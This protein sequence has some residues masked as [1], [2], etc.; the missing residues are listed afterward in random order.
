M[1]KRIRSFL[2]IIAAASLSVMTASCITPPTYDGGDWR[3]FVGQDN[4]LCALRSQE[5]LSQRSAASL[6]YYFISSRLPYCAGKIHMTLQRTDKLR[7]GR[8]DIIKEGRKFEKR[9][10]L[11]A[12]SD[13]IIQDSNIWWQQLAAHAA[14]QDGRVILYTH[15]YNESF[16]ETASRVARFKA[17]AQFNGPIIQFSWPSHRKA[18]RYATD[19]TNLQLYKPQ[20]AQIVQTLAALPEVKSL[21]LISHSLGS[22]LL[23]HGL[24]E[25]DIR[26]KNNNGIDYSKKITN[27]ILAAPDIDK[28][29]FESIASQHIMTDEKVANG[30]R[31]TIYSSAK[32]K[33][34]NLSHIIN[35][36]Q[37][38]GGT[39]CDD[40]YA[41]ADDD[42]MAID[43]KARARCYAILPESMNAE[44]R[45]GLHIVDT[46]EVSNSN[47]G[48][49]DFVNS[50]EA[51]SDFSAVIN[52]RP[53]SN[54]HR[55]S[56][57]KGNIWRLNQGHAIADCTYDK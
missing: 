34:I 3:N 52:D 18:L 56:I 1:K 8:I 11:F 19:G 51:C 41:I 30:R 32:D 37:R 26:A 47:N 35:G 36:Y 6:P 12:N 48:H 45:N 21:I 2:R 17:I 57:G 7:Y 28:Q 29:I 50:P 49:S 23:L 24:Q 27:V 20:Y 13:T 10:I 43:R 14:A 9:E 46:S 53:L 42:L 5:I 40:P 39:R 15:G 25:I 33:A 44:R 22:K 4:A 16:L 38:L 55:R 31:I 54:A